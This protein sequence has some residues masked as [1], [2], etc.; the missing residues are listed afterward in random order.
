[1]NKLISMC[2]FGV[3]ASTAACQ[4]TARSPED[5]RSATQA[6]LATRTPAM[7]GCYN[8]ALQSAPS[9]A[10]TVAVSFTVENSTGKILNPTVDAT[11]STA[12]AAV[13][14][15]VTTNLTGLV[16]NPPDA[17]DGQASFTWDFE[18]NAPAAG[19]TPGHS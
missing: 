4:F 3:A 1:M 2:L 9:A 13:Q 14:S 19:P 12:P 11:K 7:Q 6:L 18:P 16:L 15:C 17:R 5:Y 10:G 8:Q